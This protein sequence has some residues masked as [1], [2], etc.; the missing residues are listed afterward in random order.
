MAVNLS[1]WLVNVMKVCLGNLQFEHKKI[2][3]TNSAASNFMSIF[4]AN[5]K[6]GRMKDWEL[7]DFLLF[8]G[9]VK[10]M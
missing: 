2:L 3:T 8:E 6:S 4:K 10:A 9:E 5:K 7:E 1:Y